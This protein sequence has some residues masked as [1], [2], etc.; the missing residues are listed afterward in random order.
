MARK[1][2]PPNLKG[3]GEKKIAEGSSAN[4][5]GKTELPPARLGSGGMRKPGI[6][7]K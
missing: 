5:Y 4:H 7:K 6:G 1:S 3:K 2:V